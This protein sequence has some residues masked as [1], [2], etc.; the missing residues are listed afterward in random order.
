MSYS[1]DKR[2]IMTDAHIKYK[3]NLYSSFG[4]ALA[5]A[6]LEAKL[7]EEIE[8]QYRDYL[9]KQEERMYLYYE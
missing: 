8:L 5:H 4:E 2:A 1:Y 9:V 7:N 3:S 6:W